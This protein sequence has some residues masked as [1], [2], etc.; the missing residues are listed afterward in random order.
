MSR[1]QI[2]KKIFFWTLFVIFWLVSAITV[3]YAFGYR[4]SFKNGIFIYG[5]SITV[6]TTPQA[7]NIYLNGALAS[8]SFSRLNNSYHI[9]GLKPGEYFLEVTAPNFQT[10]SKKITVH[11]GMSTE[12]WNVV[13]VQNSY[14][15]EDYDS[16]GIERFFISPHK[17]LTAFTQSVGSGFT[18]KSFDLENPHPTETVFSSED[19]A[20][21]DDAKENIEWSPQAHRLIIPAVKDSEK[22]YFIASI[23]MPET[24]DLKSLSG[25][26]NLSHVRWDPRSKDV[27]FFMSSN[28]LYR[29]DLNNTQDKKLVAKNIASY[30][31][32]ARTLFYFQLPEGIVYRTA[33]DASETPVQIT[34]SAP[35]DMN[36]NSYQ[37]I[38]YDEDRIVFLNKS[39]ELYI[40]NKGKEGTYFN[41][42]SDKA[43]GSQFSDDG[44]KLLYWTDNEISV[45][46]VRKWEVPPLR[47]ENEIMPVTHLSDPIKNVQWIR[48]YEHVLFINDNKAKLIEIDNRD[49]RN[50]MD[51]LSL[52]ENNPVLV[53]NFTDGKLYYT[54]KNDQGQN[55]LHSFYFPEYSTLLQGLFPGQQS[56]DSNQ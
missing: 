39:H 28:D 5:G 3:G 13:L 23:G 54:D 1:F 45:Y 32:S 7:V 22:N 41:K 19:Y 34:S 31:L 56:T 25:M 36:D 6:K 12:F 53:N 43:G 33:L 30:D 46:F 24:L 47:S 51:V 38:I 48:D 50:T 15:H 49:H 29:I 37:I 17:N 10:W 8:G 21:T 4:F 52:N 40:F 55:V 18:V 2:S 27:I 26:E 44:K 11:S 42:L 14:E 20:F 35:A 9:S 16:A